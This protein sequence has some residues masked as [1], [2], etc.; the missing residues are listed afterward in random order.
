MPVKFKV[1]VGYKDVDGIRVAF[2]RFIDDLVR[3]KAPSGILAINQRSYKSC[4]N[5]RHE[6]L[7]SWSAS[8]DD[9]SFQRH[10]FVDR[11]SKDKNI[12]FA[13]FE[14]AIDTL[15]SD[16]TS[17]V[18]RVTLPSGGLDRSKW[19]GRPS[20][21]VLEAPNT[22]LLSTDEISGEYLYS[23]LCAEPYGCMCKSVTVVPH[24]PDAIE[25]W[26]SQCIFAPP[27]LICPEVQGGAWAREGH[28]RTDTFGWWTFSA[29]GTTTKDDKD[30][31]VYKKR[32]GSQERAF[33]KVETRDLAGRWCGCT[34]I[35]FVLVWPFACL[36][37][38][39]RKALNEDQYEELGCCCCLGL[40]QRVSE[41]RTRRYVNGHATNGFVRDGGTP[42][43][44]HWHRDPG[45]AANGSWIAKKL[46]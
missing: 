14:G 38:T 22:G 39:R 35:P 23:T 9:L 7:F 20:P 32:P 27:F 16:N 6:H 44:V 19:A 5:P 30:D 8:P 34:C 37:C 12:R 10:G 42:H 3:E 18:Y 31:E 15:G 11:K 24:G 4:G 41:T 1:D 45:L 17:A 21:P 26:S 33:Q 40:P 25:T 13:D 46:C 43:D 36:H 29:D 2:S 28:G